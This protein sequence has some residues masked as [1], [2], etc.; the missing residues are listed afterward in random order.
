MLIK[1]VRGLQKEIFKKVHVSFGA[2]LCANDVLLLP[3]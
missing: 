3:T 1:H 2:T